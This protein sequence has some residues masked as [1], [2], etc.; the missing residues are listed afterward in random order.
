MP[1]VAAEV[2]TRKAAAAMAVE[3]AVV[4]MR[5]MV[6]FPLCPG[7]AMPAGTRSVYLLGLTLG[8]HLLPTSC[9]RGDITA[10]A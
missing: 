9:Q 1:A 10:I 4:M 8:S 3:A 6:E 2:L 5:R 7:Q